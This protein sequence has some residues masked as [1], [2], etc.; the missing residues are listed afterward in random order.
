MIETGEEG[1]RRSLFLV[2]ESLSGR[3]AVML[4]AQG[5]LEHG[6][7]GACDLL[8]CASPD[9]LRAR[10]SE[11]APL[12]DLPSRNASAARA[13]VCKV[14]IVSA[15]QPRQ[16]TIELHA[17]D[18]EAGFG[19]FALLKD[20]LALDQFDRELILA[21]ERRGWNHQREALTHDLKGILNSMQISLELLSEPDA[22]PVDAASMEG[23]RRRRVAVLKEDLLRMDRALR[24]LPGAEG[25]ADPPV[26][27]FDLRDLIREI[28]AS[29][30]HLVR[31]NNVELQLHLPDQP[32]AVPGRR[33][34]IRLALFNLA[35]HRLSAMRAG[36]SLALEA[37][38]TGESVEI[39]LR[40]DVSDLRHGMND[41]DLH[42]PLTG[43]FGSEMNGAAVD[44]QVARAVVEAHGGEMHAAAAAEG[45]SQF[46]LRLPR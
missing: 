36:G 9:R 16:L 44:L 17:L 22:G 42:A 21:S 29:L 26:T 34:W 38:A 13:R 5:N 1:R 12:L 6:N 35:V 39:T 43:R 31:R 14:R 28:F 23:R 18:S 32:L 24:L 20:P 45:G 4:D 27:Q 37:V 3:A 7:Q 40:N 2:L 19:Y 25:P 11:I 30:R 33:S 10:W 15:A 46:T 8:D 41:P